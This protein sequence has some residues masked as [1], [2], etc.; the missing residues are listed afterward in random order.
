MEETTST[1]QLDGG[2]SSNNAGA[3]L[4]NVV[5]N[6]DTTAGT[7]TITESINITT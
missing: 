7:T 1:S 4:I 5:T 2:A 3:P 6:A